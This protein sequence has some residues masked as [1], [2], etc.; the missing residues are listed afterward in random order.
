M[1]S[2]D[3]VQKQGLLRFLPSPSC[4][5]DL[6][7]RDTLVGVDVIMDPQ[8]AIIFTNLLIL[9]S[10]CAELASKISQQS[11]LYSRLLVIFE[12]YPSSYSRSKDTCNVPSKLFAYSQPVLKASGKLR[13]D[14]GISEGC[15][16]KRQAYLV[17]YAFADTVEEAAKFTRYFGDLAEASSEFRGDI[18]GDR[19]WLDG[20]IP[21]VLRPSQF[22]FFLLS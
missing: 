5:I 18:L 20:D 1:V 2:M 22:L 7:E 8:T 16:T 13:R 6:V 10:E 4:P 14:V 15:G 12:A 17:Q 9:P 19:A 3:V 11:W 21:E